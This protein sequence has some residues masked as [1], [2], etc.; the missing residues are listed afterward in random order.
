NRRSAANILQGGTGI[1]QLQAVAVLGN[2][3]R[4]SVVPC[5]GHCI[6]ET[7]RVDGELSSIKV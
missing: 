4:P 5:C 2:S 3:P 6:L 7:P 1:V